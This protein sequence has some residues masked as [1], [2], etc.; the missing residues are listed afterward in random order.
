MKNY[1]RFISS[2][3]SNFIKYKIQGNI[4]FIHLGTIGQYLF[5]KLEKKKKIQ[6]ASFP[7]SY[8]CIVKNYQYFQQNTSNST[9]YIG[10]FAENVDNSIQFAGN[11][12]ENLIFV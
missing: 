1:Q 2:L 8:Q 6:I 10:N 3:K 4:K 7:K 11:F 12:L 9:Q 5:A